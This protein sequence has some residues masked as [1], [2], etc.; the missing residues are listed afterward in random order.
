MFAKLRETSAEPAW[1]APRP[2][3][4]QPPCASPVARAMDGNRDAATQCLERAHAAIPGD[5][6]T[7]RRLLEKSR[8]MYPHAGL[9]GAQARCAAAITAAEPRTPRRAPEPEPLRDATP[10]MLA[11]VRRVKA[12]EGKGHYAVLGVGREADEA[13]IRK[14]FRKLALALHPDK[15]VAPGAEV[16]FEWWMGCV[17]CIG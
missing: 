3:P 16:S 9:A 4:A 12:A 2:P 7:A 6:P 15:N 13:E 14:A 10:E 17:L 11:V 5:L 8:R 1:T